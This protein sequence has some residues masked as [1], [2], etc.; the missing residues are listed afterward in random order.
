MVHMM[1]IS[2]LWPILI[3]RQ[4]YKTSMM[5]VKFTFYSENFSTC[6]WLEKE[7]KMI[8]RCLLCLSGKS[9]LDSCEQCNLYANILL[10]NKLISPHEWTR[11]MKTQVGLMWNIIEWLW[12]LQIQNDLDKQVRK[13][14]FFYF[15]LLLY[16]KALT[17]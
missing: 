12:N 4:I 17:F 15:G 11:S 1:M 9:V 3:F 10:L 16:L 7:I 5:W 2:N 13:Q 6:K 8:C 14:F